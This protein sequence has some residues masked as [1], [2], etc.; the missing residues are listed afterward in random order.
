M[1]N[2]NEA[3]VDLIGK[4]VELKILLKM[5]SFL[6]AQKYNAANTKF[7]K[8]AFE[9]YP[10]P[11]PPHKFKY[12]YPIWVSSSFLLFDFT[13]PTYKSP[14]PRGAT[15]WFRVVVPHDGASR[16]HSMDIPQ[17]VEHLWKSDQP[18]A[19]T[20]TIEHSIHKR[21]ISMLPA[22]FELTIPASELPQTPRFNPRGH[23]DWLV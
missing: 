14:S 13:W 3:S 15:T 22:L 12:A 16:S 9:C 1:L 11:M 18:D 23:C 17:F 6:V 5:F 7:L 20:C 21:Q 10:E 8:F 19:D 2:I 4:H